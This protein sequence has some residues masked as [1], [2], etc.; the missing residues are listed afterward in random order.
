MWPWGH[1]AVGYLAHVGVLDRRFA[2]SPGDLATV[3]LVLATQLPDLIDK[4]LAWTLPI[5]PNGRSLGHSAFTAALLILLV[6][7]IARRYRRS[8]LGVAFGVG[9]ASH[10]FA[11]S[12]DSVLSGDWSALTFL[13][14]PLLPAPPQTGTSSIIGRFV[15]L[16]A[17]LAAGNVTS[18]FALELLLVAVAALLWVRQ[19]TPGLAVFPGLSN[20]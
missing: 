9:Y 15:E 17:T 2:T 4:P 18:M 13:A 8:D 7:W 3:V 5:L 6:G 14:W 16:A 10:L 11:D 20:D 1:V 19:G 12:L